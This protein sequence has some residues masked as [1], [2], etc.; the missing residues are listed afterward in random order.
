MDLEVIRNE[1]Y[2]L[3]M[4]HV[5]AEIKKGSMLMQ[6]ETGQKIVVV[7]VDRSE[8]LVGFIPMEEL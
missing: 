1:G 6:P 2:L 5:P 3:W 8:D 4:N 7:Y